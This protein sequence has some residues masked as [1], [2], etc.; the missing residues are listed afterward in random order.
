[1]L[2]IKKRLATIAVAGATA[3][4]LTATGSVASASA[5]SVHHIDVKCGKR[6]DVVK[7]K[8]HVYWSPI[9]Q[10]K[11][12]ICY[13]QA[14][15]IPDFDGGDGHGK[16]KGKHWTDEISTGNF[17]V[18]VHDRN[19]AK[20][21]LPKW[22]VWKPSGAFDMKGFRILNDHQHANNCLSYKKLS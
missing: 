7:V 19:G 17:R 14:A 16:T 13:D 18:C 21:M 10:P 8:G 4:V 15:F 1:M 3:A 11:F 9:N 6:Q 2:N 12:R 22:F 5:T 20:Y